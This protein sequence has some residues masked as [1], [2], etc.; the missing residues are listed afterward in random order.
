MV[1]IYEDIKSLYNILRDEHAKI[2]DISAKLV[3]LEDHHGVNRGFI[4]EAFKTFALERIVIYC[5]ENLR[6]QNARN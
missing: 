2:T 6:G 1:A 4:E 3:H 5:M